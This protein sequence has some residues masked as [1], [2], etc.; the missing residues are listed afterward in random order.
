MIPYD[1]T[2]PICITVWLMKGKVQRIICRLCQHQ[3]CRRSYSDIINCFWFPWF[4]F[5]DR[6]IVYRIYLVLGSR[7]SITALNETSHRNACKQTIINLEVNQIFLY[8]LDPLSKTKVLTVN[9]AF[10]K[11][12]QALSIFLCFFTVFIGQVM[13]SQ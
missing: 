6:S 8:M 4:R 1:L 2:T 7:T 5:L 13:E 10:S 9:C 11:Q 12:S 3:S